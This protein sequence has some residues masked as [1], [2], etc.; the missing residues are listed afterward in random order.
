[1]AVQNKP[2]FEKKGTSWKTKGKAK[3]E[4]PKLNQDPKAKTGPTANTDCFHCHE[5]GHWK[6][7]C[8]TYLASLKDR[9]SK[10]TSTSGTLTVY[11]MDI[12]IVDSFVNSWVFDTGSVA[13]ICHSMQGLT[14][15]RSVARGAV[16]FQREHR[17]CWNSY[18]LMCAD[19][20]ARQLEEDSNTS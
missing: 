2:N 17:I 6:R 12:L 16:V 9:G 5:K 18:I 19:Q 1:M 7:N 14:R 20:W 3:V 13:H 4:N 11:V 8:K 10:S 15:S